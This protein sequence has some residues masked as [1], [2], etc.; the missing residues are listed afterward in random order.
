[1][2]WVDDHRAAMWGKRLWAFELEAE[3]EVEENAGHRGGEIN[4]CRDSVNA[5]VRLYKPTPRH[6][7]LYNP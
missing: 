3:E 7:A 5:L 4:M 1:M 2:G 6:A